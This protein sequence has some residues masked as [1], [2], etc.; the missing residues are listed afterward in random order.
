MAAETKVEDARQRV[1]EAK[2]AW[3]E[4]Q[5]QEADARKSLRR[6]KRE[7]DVAATK[8]RM[9]ERALDDLREWEYGRRIGA[10]IAKNAPLLAGALGRGRPLTLEEVNA[11]RDFGL[12]VLSD[13]TGVDQP[14]IGSRLN[15]SARAEIRRRRLAPPKKRGGK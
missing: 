5:K 12:T 3:R 4:A 15:E 10:R 9:A 7:T 14:C 2:A 13:M 11:A 8:V 6:S 1:R